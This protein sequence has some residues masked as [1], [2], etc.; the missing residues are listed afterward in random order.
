MDADRVYFLT[1]SLTGP[2]RRR[3]GRA[4]AGL[5]LAGGLGLFAGPAAVAGKK[6]CKRKRKGKRCRI[7]DKPKC[8]SGE[9]PCFKSCISEA[10]CCMDEDCATSLGE[11][12]VDGDCVCGS[13]RG[14][15]IEA[16]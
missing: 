6:I 12:C 16:C 15:A 2:T 13:R 4:L 9:K 8:G 3:F 11:I 5:G 7:K 1:R 10:D 14:L